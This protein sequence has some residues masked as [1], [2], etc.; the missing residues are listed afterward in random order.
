MVGMAVRHRHV[1]D[2]GGLHGRVARAGPRASSVGANGVQLFK[3]YNFRDEIEHP[4]TALIFKEL[5]KM[6]MEYRWA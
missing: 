1:F 4:L 5:L 6:A 3:R 2:I